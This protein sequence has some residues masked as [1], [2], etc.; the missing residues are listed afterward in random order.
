[1]AHYGSLNDALT[2][3]GTKLN[4]VVWLAASDDKRTRAMEEAT[5]RIDRLNFAGDKAESDQTFEF[6]RT[7]DTD[8]PVEIE[9]ATY[10]LAYAFLDGVD[11]EIEFELLNQEAAKFAQASSRSDVSIVMEHLVH[12][13][14]NLMA[15]NYLKPY[16]R[17]S[18]GVSL[19]RIN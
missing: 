6:P 14:P 2:Y 19:S 15:W 10:E 13:I 11:P 16:L 17:D 18:Q 7:D 1:M 5:R 12:G 4:E 3:F 8:I 9:Q